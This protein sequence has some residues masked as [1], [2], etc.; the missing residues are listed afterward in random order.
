MGGRERG[1]EGGGG[2][3]G[4]IHNHFHSTLQRYITEY[5]FICIINVDVII[6]LIFHNIEISA[7]KL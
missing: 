2:G 1:R 7:F 5:F 4:R 3:G 6:Y